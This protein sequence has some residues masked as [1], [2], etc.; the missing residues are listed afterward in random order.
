MN[1]FC[2]LVGLP[3]LALVSQ[4]VWA[5]HGSAPSSSQPA[6]CK[7]SAAAPTPK[8]ARTPSVVFDADGR[9]WLSW[10]QQ[11]RIYVQSSTDGGKTLSK[12]VAVNREPENVLA[13]GESRPKIAIGPK[14]EIYLTWTQGLEKRFSSYIRFARSVDGGKT[15]SKPV[16]V[17]DN[18]DII[19]HSFDSLAISRDGK[20]FIAWLDAR[21]VEAAKAKN[22]PYNGSSLYYTWSDD[23]GKS[24]K[25]N[26]KAADYT[27]QC[28]RLQAAIDIDGLPLIVWRNVYPE[29]I[30]D[31]ALLKFADW[32]KP[33]RP[34]RVTHENWHIEGCPHHGPGLSIARDGRYHL[35][36]YSAAPDATG[37]FYAYSDD[38]GSHFTQPIKFGNPAA[39]PA[40]P[41]VLSVGRR[42]DLVWLE[43]DGKNNQLKTMRSTDGGANWTEPRV[44]AETESGADNPFLHANGDRVY[45]SWATEKDGL[46]VIALDGV[47]R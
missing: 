21:D 1:V 8:C 16:T 42:V 6:Y 14:G 10:V 17:N 37:L 11:G 35:T 32:D 27:C 3:A 39:M 28:C 22:Q 36:W 41:H 38:V 43:F 40:H 4:F 15:F 2:R 29:N 46:K 5:G 33:G 30:R 24:F 20:I 9:L 18:L 25:P 45:V 7:D 13:H 34:V 31:H 19:G 26:V 12:P 44:L 47:G 23:G